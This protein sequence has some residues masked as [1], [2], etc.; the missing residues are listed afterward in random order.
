MGYT[1]D[2]WEKGE[3]GD[4][5]LWMINLKFIWK[6]MARMWGNLR[7]MQRNVRKCETSGER[8]LSKQHIHCGKRMACLCRY[9]KHAK[10]HLLLGKKRYLLMDRE[11]LGENSRWKNRPAACG[12]QLCVGS[13]YCLYGCILELNDIT[14]NK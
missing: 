7:I 3:A 1:G 4:M 13:S 10:F 6:K 9:V 5:D 11:G 8:L 12:F 14:E 2:S